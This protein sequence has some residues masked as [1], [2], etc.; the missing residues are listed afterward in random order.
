MPLETKKAPRDAITIAG[1]PSSA[2]GL[3]CHRSSFGGATNR[4]PLATRRAKGVS[5]TDRTALRAKA[6]KIRRASGR[7]TVVIGDTIDRLDQ[8]CTRFKSQEGP[9]LGDVGDAARHVLE[10]GVVGL[11]VRH[12]SDVG[13]AL[14]FLLDQLRQIENRDLFLRS[15]VENLAVSVVDTDQTLQRPDDVAHVSEAARL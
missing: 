10:A 13:I 15:D 14:Q 8:P 9:N 1:P 4:S 11:I 7:D 12:E 5:A 6:R 3:R 2:V